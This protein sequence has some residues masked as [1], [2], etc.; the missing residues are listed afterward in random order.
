MFPVRNEEILSRS[1][2]A[3]QEVLLLFPA[4]VHSVLLCASFLTQ[5]LQ[6]GDS[7]TALQY[8]SDGGKLPLEVADIK[9]KWHLA[10][11]AEM[12]LSREGTK[13]HSQS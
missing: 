8:Y 12:F 6:E 9:V 5:A 3:R 7:L 2:A 1:E 10:L 11:H 4:L 13:A